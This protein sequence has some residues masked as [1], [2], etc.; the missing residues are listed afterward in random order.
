VLPPPPHTTVTVRP[1]PS[2]TSTPLANSRFGPNQSMVDEPI[3]VSPPGSI[4]RKPP[5]SV[6][7]IVTLH[8]MAVAPAGTRL[9]V[10][11]AP[12][13]RFRPSGTETV[14]FL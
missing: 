5:P 9:G 14:R 13:S 12:F 4:E 2:C 10:S 11:T 8:K 6:S 3:V 7:A 1:A